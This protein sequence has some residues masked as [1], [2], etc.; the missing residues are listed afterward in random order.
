MELSFCLFSRNLY[1]LPFW[2]LQFRRLI[3]KQSRNLHTYLYGYCLWLGRLPMA[4]IYQVS[5]HTILDLWCKIYTSNFLLWLS[6]L[7]PHLKK[8]EL[9]W[10][11]WFSSLNRLKL[12][13]F[14]FY[15]NIFWPHFRTSYL[16]CW[17][18]CLRVWEYQRYQ[19]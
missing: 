16:S 9:G 11:Y 3:E 15:L 18:A 10:Y 14:S 2:K 4:W 6:H 7:C 8:I 1:L 5:P 17:E 19:F 12:F 13:W